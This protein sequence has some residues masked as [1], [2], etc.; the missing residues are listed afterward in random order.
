MIFLISREEHNKRREH[1]TIKASPPTLRSM[2]VDVGGD[3]SVFETLEEGTNV[4]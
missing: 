1:L 2:A 3:P 4:D